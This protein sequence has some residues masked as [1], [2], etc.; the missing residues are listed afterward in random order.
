M[1]AALLASAAG[2]YALTDGLTAWTLD[3]RRENRIAAGAM[4]VP[5]L[6]V[7]DQQGRGARWFGADAPADQI[8]LVDFIYTRCMSVCRALGAEFAQLQA[9][10]AAD[11][12]SGRIGLRS[13]SFDPRD[14]VAD[15]AGYGREH[16]ARL[17]DW[18]V[19]AA[20]DPAALQALLRTAEIIAIPDGFGGFEHNGGLHVVDARGR[21]LRTFTLEAY[22]DAYA[23]ARAQ[24]APAPGRAP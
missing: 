6:D 1:L 11:G 18:A 3:Q 4:S 9:R 21:I 7:R 8:Y 22:Q 16:R 24:L 10:I 19:A 13:L 5:A 17:P 15:L 12:M 20:V 23:F 2:L 14:D